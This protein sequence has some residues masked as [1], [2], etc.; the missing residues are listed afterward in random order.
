[1]ANTYT[2]IHIQ[3]A[4]GI[5]FREGLIDKSWIECLYKYITGI[6]QNHGHKMISIN[7]TRDHIHILFGFRPTQALSDLVK[8]IKQSSSAW[9][10]D[11]S[12]TKKHFAWQGGFGAFS[13]SKSHLSNVINYINNQEEHHWK[14]SFHE[15]YIEFLDA[16]EIEYDQ[17]YIFKELE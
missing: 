2:Q 15:E 11:Q 14:K 8:H 4:F 5:K 7:G 10:N 1:M 17:R 13:Y 12:L 6:L 9:I 3:V 16:F